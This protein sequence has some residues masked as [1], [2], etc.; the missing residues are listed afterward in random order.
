LHGTKGS[1]I[2]TRSDRQELDL[3][4]GHVPMGENWGVDAPSE[5]GIL[6]V[7]GGSP[8]RV[9][10][11]KGNYMAF[12]E[13]VFQSLRNEIAPAVP[14]EDGIASMRVIDAAYES[15]INQKLITF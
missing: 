1:F 9:P 12:Y 11:E 14:G 4:K 13:N 15:A 7:D 3:D 2:K 8:E 5:Y 6:H 10:S